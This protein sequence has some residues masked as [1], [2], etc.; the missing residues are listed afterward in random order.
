VVNGLALAALVFGATPPGPGEVRSLDVEPA[1]WRLAGPDSRAQLVVTGRDADGRP[2]DRTRAPGVRFESLDPSVARADGGGEVRPVGVGTARLV[3]RFGGSSATARFVVDDVSDLRPVDFE[4]EIVPVVTRMGCN[5][6]ACHGKSSGQNG[7]RLSLLG[8]DPAAD[9]ESLAREGRGRRVFPA[10]PG[11]SLVLRK[12]TAALPHGGGKRLEVGSPEYRTIERWVAQGARPAPAAPRPAL[13][14][15]E[16]SAPIRRLAPGGTQQLRV[17]A[18]RADGSE[19]DVTRLARFES[20]TPDLAAVDPRGTVSAVEGVGEA[21]VTARFG[22]LVGVARFLVPATGPAPSWSPPAPR[23][24]LDELVF[25]RLRELG[26]PP[27]PACT[28]AEFARRSALDVCGAL[29]KPEEVEAL[30]ADPD[31]EK[32]VKWVDRLLDR[33]EY[34]DRFA[35]TWSAVLRNQRTLGSL[36]Q[37]GTFAFHAWVRQALAENRPYDRLVAEILT[38][39]GDPSRN[40]PV[41]WYRHAATAEALADDAARLFLGVRLQCARCHHHPSERWGQADYFGFAALFSRV[42]RKPGPD[43]VTPRVFLLPSGQAT[44]PATGNGYAP[45]VLGGPPLAGLGPRDDPRQALADWLRRPDNPY[46]ARAV[47]NRYWKHFFGRGLVEPEDDFRASNPATNPEPL[48]ALADGFVR[49]GYDLKHLVRTLATSRAYERSSAPAGGN[50]R[51][52]RSFARLA[53]RRLPAEVL[54]DAIDTVTGAPRTFGDLPRGFRA[55]QLPDEGF[56]TPGRFLDVFGRPR[57]ETVCECER[58]S[59]ANLSQSLFLLNA[60]EVERQVAHPEGRAARWDADLR[61]D[62]EKVVELYRIAL[63]RAPTPDERSVCLGH[64]ARRRA[65]GRLR[66]G[67]ED[68]VWTLINTKEFQFVQ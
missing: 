3:V 58:S 16:V 37:P 34:A 67:F 39:R 30:E 8:S 11:A 18:R 9:F 60:G 17:V 13:A 1:V 62:A 64:L 2:V 42:G 10:A 47:V 41:V 43:P 14:S 31:P 68:L 22:G 54:L 49:H 59:E 21:A 52:R 19:E 27:S 35:M 53:P 24:R 46:F 57:R 45:R 28:D 65:E 51:D 6:G 38:A 32:R 48:D 15:V 44:D 61:P 55:V 66:Q 7:F 25:A 50:E 5:A 12:P 36:S 29:P 63:A 23:H 26:I 56:D 20:S 33:P 4:A 40:P